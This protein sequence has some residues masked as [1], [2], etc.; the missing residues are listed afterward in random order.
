MNV[1]VTGAGGFIG[2]Y[3]VA[4]LV[5][6][7]H[8]VSAVVRPGSALPSGLEHPAVEI[9]RSDLRRPAPELA[10]HLARSGA[11]VHLANASTGSPRARFEGSVL[12]TELL[13]DEARG[14]GWAGRLVHV[15]SFAVYGF[16]QVSRGGVIDETTPLEPD[17]ARRDD[18]AWT[19]LW[20]E[21]V[22]RAAAT[23][24]EIE[25]VIIR[26]GA[27][28]GRERR[29]QHRLGRPLG[30]RGLLLIGGLRLMP[31][32]YVENTA[33]LIA[34]CADHPRA[35]G[36]VF[37]A[38]DPRPLRQFQYLRRWRASTPEPVRV[39]P[40]PLPAYRA[41]GAAYGR[42]ERASGGRVRTPGLARPYVMTPSFG[43]FRYDATKA[44]RTLGWHPPIGRAEA[45]AR[46]F[47]GAREP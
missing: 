25:T 39:I 24:G 31:L 28:Y 37:N 33:S 46:T 36:E 27:V 13:L 30:D 43:S 9:V 2:R 10:E 4:D 44:S 19:K 40:L 1:M 23:A 16:N 12:A 17:I 22:V 34:E 47:G 18:Y 20:Q 6:R 14:L 45:L 38:V 41:I 26:P 8:E 11:L 35:A 5:R 7:G 3:V 21:R 42:M 32:T 29:F 15:S